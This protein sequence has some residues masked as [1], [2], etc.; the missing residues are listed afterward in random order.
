MKPTSLF[1]QNPF[2]SRLTFAASCGTTTQWR[3]TS[4][5]TWTSSVLTTPTERCR[6]IRPSATSCTWWRRKT[7]MC[8]NLTPSISSAGSARGPLP[9]TF[10]R[11]SPKNSSALHPSPW[12][13]SL[14]RER[15][16][17]IS[18]SITDRS[19]DICFFYQ[20]SLL[21][22][23]CSFFSSLLTNLCYLFLSFLAKPMHHHGADCLK[24]RV[25]VVG[26]KGFSKTSLEK[27]K[28]DKTDKS[29]DEE[30]IK[31]SAVGGVH[32]PSNQLPAGEGSFTSA[33]S[34]PN[35]AGCVNHSRAITFLFCAD[36]LCLFPLQM[37]L[38]RWSQ[39]FRGALAALQHSSSPCRFSLPWSQFYLPQ[40]YTEVHK[41]FKNR[42]FQSNAG[43]WK[44]SLRFFFLF[45]LLEL[46]YTSMEGVVSVCVWRV[47]SSEC[48]AWI[49][50]K[51]KKDPRDILLPTFL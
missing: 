6:P 28:A 11:N 43:H 39:K 42:L 34:N 25:D 23:C 38:L 7:M 15:A 29:L 30:N 51:E 3:C 14:D 12:E 33:A 46:F 37:I 22:C 5:T 44:R 2:L 4:T 13:R 8:A 17:T 50:P 21:L 41:D 48:G 31:F 27:S 24:L 18:V 47:C 16:T 20:I 1:T 19:L 45:F 49:T 26:R 35:S 10:Q 40:F 36:P 32:N 9:H